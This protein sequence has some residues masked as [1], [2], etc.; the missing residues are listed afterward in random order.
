[1]EK[2]VVLSKTA[3]GFSL[4]IKEDLTFE[5]V[6]EEIRNL[7]DGYSSFFRGQTLLIQLKG[8]VLDEHE[9]LVCNNICE[10]Y[11]QARI[12]IDDR[13]SQNT[14]VKKA[15]VEENKATKSKLEDNDNV[16]SE[17]SLETLEAI[18]SV[19][20]VEVIETVEAS[21]AENYESD[22]LQQSVETV[23]EEIP[24]LRDEPYVNE[25]AE[26][27]VELNEPE[28]KGYLSDFIT[29]EN[30]DDNVPAIDDNTENSVFDFCMK[31]AEI[32][33]GCLRSGQQ[34]SSDKSILYIGNVNPGAILYAKGSIYVLGS[35]KGSAFAGQG[36]NTNAFVYAS[37]MEPSQIQIS[38]IVAMSEA[39]T[40]KWLKSRRNKVYK[41][42]IAYISGDNIVLDSLSQSLNE[43]KTI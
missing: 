1:M 4:Y 10:Y 23:S 38:D 35:L 32:F 40:M 6:K 3:E 31:N 36:G 41:D 21:K 15:I 11:T 8:R 22:K 28:I 33:K 18:D 34:L 5:Q 12:I 39:N 24:V 16:N 29:E 19:E 30:N 2:N 9:L 17:A 7:F 13:E 20:S 26:D 27:N 37:E 14:E 43:I 42:T 25:Q